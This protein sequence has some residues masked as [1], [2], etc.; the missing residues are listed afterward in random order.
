MHA[1]ST[2]L[3]A[4]STPA[5]LPLRVLAYER[6][7]SAYLDA[8]ERGEAAERC[9]MYAR[10]RALRALQIV[11]GSREIARLAIVAACEAPAPLALATPDPA[12]GPA[13]TAELAPVVVARRS[14]GRLPRAAYAA[15]HATRAALSS[16]LVEAFDRVWRSLWPSLGRATL[17]EAFGEWCEAHERELLDI[18]CETAERGTRKLEREM[19]RVWR[20]RATAVELATDDAY[21]AAEREA[22]AGVPF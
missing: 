21:L 7:H 14:A 4:I 15:A 17:A 8:R 13:T 6:A 20:A 3:S 5:P 9:A 22:L 2:L 19:D 16:D 1:I 11:P 18:Q 12:P 10:D